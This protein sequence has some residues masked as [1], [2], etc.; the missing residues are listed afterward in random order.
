[1]TNYSQISKGLL[2]AVFWILTGCSDGD[3]S[4]NHPS[5][6]TLENH[7]WVLNSFE[8]P[9]GDVTVVPSEQ[10]SI[11]FFD[12]DTEI[13]TGYV[14]CNKFTSEYTVSDDLV[15]IAVVAPTEMA[16]GPDEEGQSQFVVN[17]LSNPAD[18]SIVHEVLLLSSADGSQL[19]FY[20][21]EGP[22]AR[23]L[24]ATECKDGTTD[25]RHEIATNQDCVVWE[26]DGS[27]VLSI[28][29][30]NACLNCCPGT[31]TADIDMVG[32]NITISETEGDDATPCYC[33]C[34]YDLTYGMID[35]EPGIYTI[36]FV[37][38]Y[39]IQEDEILTAT[40]DLISTA[41][42]TFCAM[43]HEYPWSDGETP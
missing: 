40:V 28:I 39:L 18:Y 5:E 42:G 36:T 32:S 29:H 37:E 2:T 1:M 43:R 11:L 14:M 30:V 24:V 19:E 26:Y 15:N 35:I 16:C 3:I 13:V 23:L 6:V 34:L 31:I 22:L 38:P 17:V 7:T 20:L 41:T 4:N 25:T 27:G 9:N 8:D 10:A 12:E 21:H 33:L